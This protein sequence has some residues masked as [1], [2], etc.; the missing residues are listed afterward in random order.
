M[1]IDSL[2]KENKN[3]L[4][5]KPI[6]RTIAGTI[7]AIIVLLI[8]IITMQLIGALWLKAQLIKFQQDFYAKFGTMEAKA[9][10]EHLEFIRNHPIIQYS[11]I[12]FLIV[13]AVGAAYHIYL[14]SSAWSAT[15]GKRLMKIMIIKKDNLPL[16]LKT[17]FAHYF[18]SIAP[19]IFI[20]YILVTKTAYNDPNF[21]ATITSNNFNIFLAAFFGLWMQS[22]LFTKNKTTAYDLICKTI[23]INGQTAAKFPWTKNV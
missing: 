11:F 22:N 9:T 23:L 14:N 3:K 7:D 1:N 10:P 13:F 6:R 2:S 19:F 16:S 20:T 8:R 18:L 12:T 4:L 5:A 15:L 17:A 21:L